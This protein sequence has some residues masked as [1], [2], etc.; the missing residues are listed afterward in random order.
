MTG[1]LITF[2]LASFLVLCWSF[3]QGYQIH[4]SSQ[5]A[6]HII[7]S[8][9]ATGLSIFSHCMIMMYFVGTGRVI[10]E[11]VEKGGLDPKFVDETKGYRKKI[12]RFALLAITLVM[13]Q[14]ILGGGIHTKVLPLWIHDVLGILTIVF[15]AYVVY[16][17]TQYLVRNHL[18]GH[19]VA[20]LFEE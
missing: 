4:S 12:F 7:I 14:T 10:R 2:N 6:H 13:S 20:R 5:I 15:S 19:N 18:L 16:L 1:I 11:T 3:I 17:E 8:L 9:I